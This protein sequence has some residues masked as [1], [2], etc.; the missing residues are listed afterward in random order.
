MATDADSC[1]GLTHIDSKSVERFRRL[2]LSNVALGR[3]V[4]ASEMG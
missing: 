2:A 4:I 3:T 1:F